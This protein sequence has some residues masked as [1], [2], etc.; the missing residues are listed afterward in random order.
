MGDNPPKNGFAIRCGA[1]SLRSDPGHSFQV[2]E[3]ECLP[4]NV[5]IGFA[6]VEDVDD[7]H[8]ERE[9]P[10]IDQT[11]L[12]FATDGI[13]H[14][15]GNHQAFERNA[16]KRLRDLIV[17]QPFAHQY[18]ATSRTPAEDGYIKVAQSDALRLEPLA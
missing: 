18:A 16:G 12:G 6:V 3:G 17:V 5:G 11:E 8:Q 2:L 14:D 10:Q 1:E 4:G 13:A 15:A 7:V 9:I